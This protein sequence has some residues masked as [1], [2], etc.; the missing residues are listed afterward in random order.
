MN[1]V[2]RCPFCGSENAAPYSVKSCHSVLCTACGGEGPEA[3]SEE[4]AIA[5][6]N[7]RV[8]LNGIDGNPAFSLEN[9]AAQVAAAI[10]GKG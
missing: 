5:A 1:E 7:S 8:N 10:R 9:V 2:K 4:A 6:W 3:T